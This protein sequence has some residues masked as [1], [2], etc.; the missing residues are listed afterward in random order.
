M[1]YGIQVPTEYQDSRFDFRDYPDIAFYGNRWMAENIPDFIQD[2]R[3]LVN[4]VDESDFELEY[5]DREVIGD[6]LSS[7][8]AYEKLGDDVIQE[9]KAALSKEYYVPE[10]TS[11][12]QILN[13]ITGNPDNYR[14]RTLRG[15]VQS[16]WI[17]ILYPSADYSESD[18]STIE[19]L[20]FNQG[21]EWE[22]RE[23]NEFEDIFT[24]EDARDHSIDF[25]YFHYCTCWRDEDIKASVAEAANVFAE[26]V[27]LF[28]FDS[29]VRTAC[30]SEAY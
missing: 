18:I 6:Y 4:Y 24:P 26:E 2:I 27:K 11:V 12:C 30:Y 20:Y 5:T 10:A 19:C 29:W 9:I 14:I 8:L 13:I 17:D 3:N 16:E 15:S 28:K 1:I 25:P 22:I 7:E 23:V 21:S